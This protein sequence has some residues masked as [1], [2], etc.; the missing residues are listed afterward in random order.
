MARS[1]GRNVVLILWQWFTGIHIG[2]IVATAWVLLI[3]AIVGF[4]LL[5]DG[6]ALSIALTAGSGLAFLI[7]V[8]YIAIDTGFGSPSGE[9]EVS[10]YENLKHYPLYVL[11]LLFPLILIVAFFLLES[12]LVLGVL[13]ETKPMGKPPYCITYYSLSRPLIRNIV[14]LTISALFFAIGQ[15]FVFVVSKHLCSATSGRIDGALF[16]TLFTLL[17][18]TTLWYFWSSITEDDW[19]DDP[20]NGTL[21]SEHNYAWSLGLRNLIATNMRKSCNVLSF[22]FFFFFFCFCA[23]VLFSSVDRAVERRV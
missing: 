13:Q 10:N 14:F 15:V 18:V 16:E 11:Y 3:N 4:Q 17:S 2:A 12:V 19:A 5:D 6:T 23:F 21:V 8:G 20:L 22:V 1:C 9:L 7:G